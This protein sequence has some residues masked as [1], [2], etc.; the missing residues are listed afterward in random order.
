MVRYT[1]QSPEEINV[2]FVYMPEGEPLD[3][4]YLK[5]NLN[6]QDLLDINFNPMKQ[7]IF[8]I[9]GWLNN[10]TTSSWMQVLIFLIYKIHIFSENI[11]IFSYSGALQLREEMSKSLP[12]T[13]VMD[14]WTDHI[15]YQL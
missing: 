15:S 10:Y 7:N 9:H 5:Y 14:P 1:P 3:P 11:Y 13:G 8:M 2:T 4:R 6:E 12:W